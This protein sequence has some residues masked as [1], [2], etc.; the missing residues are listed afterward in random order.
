MKKL[1][2][3]YRCR[4]WQQKLL[5]RMKATFVLLFLFVSVTFASTKAQ[6]RISI[7]AKDAT[8][9]EVLDQIESQ[10]NLGFV[11][12]LDELD[13]NKRFNIKESGISVFDLLD[14]LLEGEDLLYRK[15]GDNIIIKSQSRTS[16]T[17]AQ[18][19]EHRITG[20][21]VDKTGEPLP[22]VNV[23]EKGNPTHGVITGI[24]GGY[25]IKVASSD[26]ILRYSFIGYDDQ[27]LNVAGRQ[28]INVTLV[29]EFTDLDEVVVVGY[30]I[31]KKESLTGAISTVDKKI[32]E[33]RPVANTTELLQGVAPGLTIT[34]NNAGRI[35][36]PGVAINIR[37][38][39]SRSNPGVLVVIDGI[40]HEQ[41]NSLALDQINPN[42]I[43]SV[44]ILK[45]A[46]AAIY[47]ARAAGGVIV[48]TTKSGK[49]EKPIIQASASYTLNVP[50]SQAETTNI[51]QYIEMNHDAFVNDGVIDNMFVSNMNY[52][53]ENNITWE[54]VKRNDNKYTHP[55]PYDNTGTLLVYRH[56]D[57]Q[58]VLYDPALMQNYN[59][60]VSGKTNKSNYYTSI[61]VVDQQGMLAVGTNYNRKYFLRV[62]YD[63]DVTNKIQLRTNISLERQKVT[64]PTNYNTGQGWGGMMMECA[65]V[66]A[67]N[68]EYY[69][70]GS[71]QNPYAAYEAGGDAT[72]INNRI[73]ANVGAV[74][75]PFK[76]LSINTDISTNIDLYDREWASLGYDLY[77]FRNQFSRNSN[78]NRNS[79]GVNFSKNWHYV[80]NIYA[81]YNKVIAEKHIVNAMVGYSH[82]EFNNHSFG[83]HRRL[84]LISPENPHMSL[85]D[86]DEQYNYQSKAD[87]AL[88]SL[89]SRVSYDYNSKY[90]VEG[91]FRRDGSSR[92]A[93]GYKWS[94][95]YGISGAWAI[96]NEA[97]MKDINSQILSF[98]KIRGSFG[99]MGNQ[100]SIGLYDFLARIN[101]SG[102]YPF[103]HPSSPIQ[104]QKAALAGLASPTRTW[105]IVETTNIGVDIMTLDNN[106]II[107]YDYFVKNNKNMFYSKEFPAV[108]GIQ[109]P[110]VN[111]A[112]LK[113][114]G[115][116]LNVQYQNTYRDLKYSIGFNLS[117]TDNE[118][119]RLDEPVTPRH[120]H[121]AFVEGHAIGSYYGLA[122]D[123]II[124]NEEELAEYK[125]KFTSGIPNTIRVGDVRY[126]DLDG[127]GK[128]EGNVYEVDENGNPT[129]NSGDTK[130]LGNTGIDYRY[131]ITLSA[132]WKGFTFNVL[133]QGVD[134]WLVFDGAS[135]DSR[136][137]THWAHQPLRHFY[138]NTWTE[139]NP[140]AKYPKTTQNKG[141]QG[142][143]YTMSDA[144]HVMYNNKYFRLKNIRFGY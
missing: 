36:N 51:L 42:D 110:T 67:P 101:I 97:F 81:D 99:Q 113:T 128:L 39:T 98:A 112:H 108:L 11:F 4:Y 20:K 132:E 37:G 69:N 107:N 142:Y 41:N 76:D 125:S 17:N 130:L 74:I 82:E 56:T 46:Q 65:P 94:N 45:D 104:A 29:E 72:G 33:N 103:G 25:T 119:V 78:S 13:L 62:K 102:V 85:G 9:L 49:S 84:G 83:A 106:L 40:P 86:A 57:W 30:G 19:N 89:F 16:Q 133:F 126:K 31:K 15:V 135:W 68:G 34:R 115:W 60:S 73:K 131:G 111:G 47:G 136:P 118:I 109:A 48:I 75:K 141:L 5:R 23:Y 54:D 2:K 53:K 18:Q 143:N 91:I 138:G 71:Y 38:A 127:D 70:Y 24:D 92:F 134:D 63:Y 96:T 7:N 8:F 80:G 64:E 121:N 144:P 123:G 58:D 122:Y 61:G 137:I 28:E 52:I 90:F 100:S 3:L 12:S 10:S 27:E 140:N 1:I 87:W 95:F 116:E 88:K 26:V 139:D 50:D 32:I 124:Q 105:E 114:W 129:E 43:E 6:E 77:N 59:L 120:G 21:V 55:W 22:G 117:N 35:A 66:F 14:K 44:S 79:A 93:E